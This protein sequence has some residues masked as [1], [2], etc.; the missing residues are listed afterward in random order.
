[1]AEILGV[2]IDNLTVEEVLARI[3]G[4]LA[5]GRQHYLVLPYSEFIVRAAAEPEF[6]GLLNR[7]DLSL[8]ESRGLFLALKL[9]GHP[10]REQIEGVNLVRRMSQSCSGVFLLGGRP[11]VSEAAARA[12]GRN[13]V[14]VSD[15]YG[16][17]AA[18]VGSVN[19]LRPAVLFVALGMP[20][21]EKWIAANLAK[22]PSV[23]VAVGV[24]GALDFISGRIRRAPK[25]VRA[26]G[27]EW[28]WRFGRQPRRIR[29]ALTA[30]VIF[31]C[32]IL[33]S[34]FQG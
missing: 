8:C 32:L 31:P 17:L 30:A 18:A 4:F 28:L 11:G 22:M 24:G 33:R 7:A 6:L 20:E 19:R 25:L 10:V 16:G 21:Q 3:D 26:A 34:K 12:L 13:V 29:R 15:G 9:L 2:K 14:G 5:D 23:K 27:L 1:M